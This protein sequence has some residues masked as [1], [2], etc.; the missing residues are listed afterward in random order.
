[1]KTWNSKELSI[2]QDRYLFIDTKDLSELLGRTKNAIEQKASQ[3]GLTRD[4][5]RAFVRKTKYDKCTSCL[6]WI[7]SKEDKMGYGKFVYEN[8]QYAHRYS[9][10]YFIG[11]IPD[12]MTIDHLCE[13][14]SCVNPFHLTLA[15]QRDNIL[16]GNNI[17]ARNAR[18]THCKRGH[19][20][21]PE[22][23]MLLRGGR[24]QCRECTRVWQRSRTQ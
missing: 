10:E 3:L 19:E 20:F 13:N 5:F 4:K 16:R 7:G 17:C 15:T 14:P 6:E 9:Y 8:G 2:L 21:T 12:G 24:R 1:M 11:P 18:K 22:N 23:T